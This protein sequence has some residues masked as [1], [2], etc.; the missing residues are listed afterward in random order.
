MC[1]FCHKHGEGKKWYLQARNYS[2][3]LLS[4]ARRRKS[5]QEFFSDPGKLRKSSER[6]R[7]LAKAPAF[8]RRL[9]AWRIPRRM[10]K[11]HY[12]QVVPIEEIE[13]ILGF[14]NSIV[15]VT[16]LCRY[17]NLGLE[18]RY[19]FGVSMGPNGG[20]DSIIKGL[21]GSFFP[22]PFSFG[23]ETLSKEQALAAMKDME[24]EGLCHTVWTFGPPF[25]G[26]IC[27]CDRADCLAM[28]ATVGVEVPVMFRAEYVAE[29][30]PDACA[31][32]REC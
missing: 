1:E 13:Q 6:L 3:D 21:D 17:V 4:D 18:K 5:A 16:C 15:R 9:M 24:H 28:Q 8:V 26:G 23:L 19:C 25:I 30:D 20:L 27:N 7:A 22:G 10:K 11:W 12:G 14:V 32:C 2:Q 31:G 29:V